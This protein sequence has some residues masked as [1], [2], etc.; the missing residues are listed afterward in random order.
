MLR[1]VTPAYT[2]ALANQK[3]GTGKTTTLVHLAA[4]LAARR[5]R[6]LVLDLDPQGSATSW[7]G[8][9]VPPED[10]R[11]ADAL[12]GRGTLAALVTPANVPGVDVV[13]SS[14]W[15]AGVEKRLAAAPQ[16]ELRVRRAVAALPAR[17]TVVLVDTPPALSVLT[18]NALAAADGVL[19]PVETTALSLAGLAALLDTLDAVRVDA[20][21]ALRLAG[22]VAVRVRKTLLAADVLDKLRARFGPLVCRTVIPE[23]VRVAE[24]PGFRAPVTDT[25]PTSAGALAYRALT[26]ELLTRFRKGTP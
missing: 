6:V 25:A 10:T 26:R 14:P 16:G 2:L 17:W 5:Q 4:G 1:P 8:V 18:L 7:L 23:S 20:N 19:V 11:L 22:V 24:S 3:G 12:T 13:P 9:D 21:P 15:L